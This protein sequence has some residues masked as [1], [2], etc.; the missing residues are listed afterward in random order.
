[1]QSLFAGVLQE[2]CGPASVD[3]CPPDDDDETLPDEDDAVPDEEPDDEPDEEEDDSCPPE[4]DTPPPASL[5]GVPVVELVQP[6]ISAITTALPARA[7]VRVAFECMVHRLAWPGGSR[8]LASA[9][10]RRGP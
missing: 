5:V 10:R 6:T 2:P 9:E 8:N 3:P 4:D 1:M 7:S